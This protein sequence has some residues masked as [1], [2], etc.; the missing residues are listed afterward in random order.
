MH[1]SKPVFVMDNTV[2][3]FDLMGLEHGKLVRHYPTAG[4]KHPCPRQVAF[5][6]DFRVVVC[7]SDYGNVHIFDRKTSQVLDV[8]RHSRDGPVRTI[9]VVLCRICKCNI[10]NVSRHTQEPIAMQYTRPLHRTLVKYIFPNGVITLPFAEQGHWMPKKP[11]PHS[12][13]CG[14]SSSF[15]PYVPRLPLYSKIGLFFL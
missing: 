14:R 7:G 11:G 5:G 1:P 6:E 12:Q 8:L 15:L 3:G 9:T 2:T 4:P 13:S 10:K